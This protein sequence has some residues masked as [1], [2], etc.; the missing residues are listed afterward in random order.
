MFSWRRIFFW[1]L[2]SVAAVGLLFAANAGRHAL[3]RYIRDVH[4]RT[5]TR[6]LAQW[7]VELRDDPSPG[8]LEYVE[9][10]YRYEDMPEYL[11]TEVAIELAAQRERTMEAIRAGLREQWE[12]EERRAEAW[13]RK[14]ADEASSQSK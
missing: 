10:H 5:V 12:K 8:M 1:S 6:M 4:P 11:N 9:N 2:A 13:H 14:M 3:G 7:E